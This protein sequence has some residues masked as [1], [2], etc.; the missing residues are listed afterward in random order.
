MQTEGCVRGDAGG[1]GITEGCALVWARGALSLMWIA[2]IANSSTWMV[3][4]L[5]YLHSHT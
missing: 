4:P 3:A 5:A 1:R 2:R